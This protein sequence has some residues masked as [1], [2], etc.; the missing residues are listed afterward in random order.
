[1]GMCDNVAT[2][3]SDWDVLYCQRWLL[4]TLGLSAD[5][6]AAD[7]AAFQAFDRGT[8]DNSV[9]VWVFGLHPGGG[10]AP[11]VNLPAVTPKEVEALWQAVSGD[12]AWVSVMWTDG[13]LDANN[14]VRWYGVD[15]NTDT[16]SY[17]ATDTSPTGDGWKSR[18]V[19]DVFFPD[20]NA[21]G[22]GVDPGFYRAL[23][24]NQNQN[25]WPAAIKIRYR[26]IDRQP[27]A[28]EDDGTTY[29]V[30]CRVGR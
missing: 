3:G 16:N 28:G 24:T 30:I 17:V 26:I 5:S 4:T 8:V 1:M 15:Y 19:N 13:Q 2:T 22:S 10:T 12:C 20:Y 29:E 21:A 6:Y 11:A 14:L 7:L 27:A 23:W 25:N 9:T 18:T